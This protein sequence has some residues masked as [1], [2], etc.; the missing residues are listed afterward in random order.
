MVE[1]HAD[2]ALRADAEQMLRLGVGRVDSLSEEVIVEVLDLLV[3]PIYDVNHSY[4]GPMLT[5]SVIT[6]QERLEQESARVQS[7]M[8]NSPINVMYADR[9]LVIRYMNPA[10]KRQLRELQQYL[11]VPVDSM[12]G[13]FM[14]GLL[15]TNNS[16][17]AVAKG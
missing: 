4:V 12:I 3:S 15:W 8:E 7:M 13:D 5:W 6:S 1:E 14:P 9:D 10:S 17:A 2:D 16:A 11:P